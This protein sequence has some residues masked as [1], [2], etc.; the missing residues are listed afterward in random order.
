MFRP[1]TVALRCAALLYTALLCTVLASCKPSAGPEGAAPEDNSGEPPPATETG[2]EGGA[3]LDDVAATPASCATAAELL[4]QPP[5]QPPE[6]IDLEAARADLESLVPNVA[7]TRVTQL[8][9]TGSAA[10]ALV[11]DLEGMLGTQDLALSNA[12]LNSLV[13]I[14]PE[15]AMRI[16][17]FIAFDGNRML[18]ER[19]M[20]AAIMSRLGNEGFERIAE[21]H[22]NALSDLERSIAMSG[23]DRVRAFPLAARD[24][25]FHSTGLC[26]RAA[27]DEACMRL[28]RDLSLIWPDL[29]P[30]ND[31]VSQLVR[32]ETASVLQANVTP[33][34]IAGFGDAFSS[35]P[36]A[37]SHSV[38]RLQSLGLVEGLIEPSIRIATSG[39]SALSDRRRQVLWLLNTGQRLESHR[40]TLSARLAEV[41][42]EPIA[43]FVGILALAAGVDGLSESTAD[44]IA[45]LALQGR[46]A[47]STAAAIAAIRLGRGDRVLGAMS[48]ATRPNGFNQVSSAAA[49]TD[50][51]D[52]VRSVADAT[53]PMALAAE[54]ASIW[55][56]GRRGLIVAVLM[57]ST[58]NPRLLELAARAAPASPG[59]A[60]HLADQAG[61]TSLSA[62][63]AWWLTAGD[64]ADLVEETALASLEDPLSA[65]RRR[66]VQWA[67]VAGVEIET[68][69]LMRALSA[70]LGQS[71]VEPRDARAPMLYRLLAT[72]I[73]L[74]RALEE[75]SRHPIEGV[76][77][78]E[79][80]LLL[81]H[82][83]QASCP[84]TE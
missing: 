75:V 82:A 51:A 78:S 54:A 20:G 14:S 8:A 55:A 49:L 16:G 43:A 45:E 34:W 26:M 84:E 74:S 6:S 50:P 72:N 58:P 41:E 31:A 83:Y 4:R 80:S 32:A 73:E 46:S 68:D 12:I 60:A 10:V 24:V 5:M 21:L 62:P 2:T 11:A 53:I 71:E 3:T 19:H 64:H 56:G 79:R 67:N 47:T 17:S 63:V 18:P 33:E 76:G 28:F 42:G 22:T 52:F 39:R 35:S 15:D 44:A 57:E 7:I 1:T 48:Q 25:F 69:A 27:D 70:P 65:R 9:S 36:G 29:S 37:A 59:L 23:L 66:A 13:S 81:A 77:A 30:R 40:D 61:L 38:E